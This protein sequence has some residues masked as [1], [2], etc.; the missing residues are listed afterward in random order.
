[1]AIRKQTSTGEKVIFSIEKIIDVTTKSNTIYTDIG[2]ELN[3]FNNDKVQFERPVWGI[4]ESDSKTGERDG[5]KRRY[6]EYHRRISKKPRLL[7]K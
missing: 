3:D 1:M 6:T 7:S 4:S 5:T 2:Q